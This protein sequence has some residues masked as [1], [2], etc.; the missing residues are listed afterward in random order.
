MRFLVIFSIV[1]LSTQLL[2]CGTGHS[3]RQAHIRLQ[4]QFAPVIIKLSN[5]PHDTKLRKAIA[6]A[7][8]GLVDDN[9]VDRFA[10]AYAVAG[11]SRLSLLFVKSTTT[12][13][14]LESSDAEV[15]AY[16]KRETVVAARHSFTIIRQR[17]DTLGGSTWAWELNEKTGVILISSITGT[18]SAEYLRSYLQSRQKPI[19]E[20]RSDAERISAPATLQEIITDK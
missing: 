20:S 17:F 1:F 13:I 9:F 3:C 10:A 15:V 5:S 11:G 18:Y 12:S 16:L 4:L 8:K 14:S 6:V 2:S 19:Y 7:E